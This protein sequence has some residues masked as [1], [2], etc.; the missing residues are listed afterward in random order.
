MARVRID[1]A[2][3]D[4]TDLY[5]ELGASSAEVGA[6][7]GFVGQVR[8]GD[9]VQDLQYLDLHHYPGMTERL[10]EDILQQAESRWPLLAA[11]VYH[12]IGP[13]QPG[14]QIVFVGVA[15]RH[16]GEA[17][18]AASFIMDYLKTQ[19]TFWKREIDQKGSTWVESRASDLARKHQW[20]GK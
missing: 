17:F 3:F 4:V 16:R 14:E 15:A 20:Q 13:L 10:I 12:R 2:D 8:A 1:S 7:V 19:A 18:E 5:R 11:L 9:A 6:V